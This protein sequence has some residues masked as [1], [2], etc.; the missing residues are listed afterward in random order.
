V[1]AQEELGCLD[2]QTQ[3]IETPAQDDPEWPTATTFEKARAPWAAETAT[4]VFQQQ[5]DCPWEPPGSFGVGMYVVV[6]NSEK[7]PWLWTSTADTLMSL[8]CPSW[9]AVSANECGSV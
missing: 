5:D 2:S 1:P 6:P 9:Q 4:I 8:S 3:P 7:H